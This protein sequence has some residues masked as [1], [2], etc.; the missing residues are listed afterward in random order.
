MEQAAPGPGL[1]P[2]PAAHARTALGPGHLPAPTAPLK[3]LAGAAGARAGED[4]HVATNPSLQTPPS[5]PFSLCDDLGNRSHSNTLLSLSFTCALPCIRAQHAIRPRRT[6]HPLGLGLPSR[7]GSPPAPP[8]QG[9]CSNRRFLNHQRFGPPR[10]AH[11]GTQAR[12]RAPHGAHVPACTLAHT[13]CMLTRTLVSFPRLHCDPAYAPAVP[14]PPAPSLLDP[15][16]RGF[17][18]LTFVE[19]AVTYK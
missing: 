4:L 8:P 12:R 5:C 15:F 9:H 17:S 10:A 13:S 7:R 14:P 2:G 6:V 19:G 3:G 11:V 16:Q 1:R 18:S